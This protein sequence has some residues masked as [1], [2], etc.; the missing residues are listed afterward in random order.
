MLAWSQ[1]STVDSRSNAHPVTHCVQIAALKHIPT[2]EERTTHAGAGVLLTRAY[3]NA[4][5]AAICLIA[6]NVKI[7][8]RE[9]TIPGGEGHYHTSTRNQ[10]A[11]PKPR[12]KQTDSMTHGILC[13]GLIHQTVVMI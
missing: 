3:D 7:Y 1:C 5:A 4:A 9:T 11:K 2:T 10:T 13:A 6:A 8:H 12:P